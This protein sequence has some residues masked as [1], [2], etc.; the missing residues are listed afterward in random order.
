MEGQAPDDDWDPSCI[1]IESQGEIIATVDAALVTQEPEVKHAKYGD[2][3][4]ALDYGLRPAQERAWMSPTEAEAEAQLHSDSERL[5]HPNRCIVIGVTIDGLAL[6]LYCSNNEDAE[7]VEPPQPKPLQSEQEGRVN[8]VERKM[9]VW[10]DL[11]AKRNLAFRYKMEL[12]H[13]EQAAYESHMAQTLRHFLETPAQVKLVMQYMLDQA[14][15]DFHLRPVVHRLGPLLSDQVKE[16]RTTARPPRTKATAP[17]HGTWPLQSAPEPGGQDKAKLTRFRIYSCRAKPGVNGAPWKE[18]KQCIH[19]WAKTAPLSAMND[20]HLIVFY[21][22]DITT[23]TYRVWT[24][25]RQ[26]QVAVA[27]WKADALPR[28]M[29]VPATPDGVRTTHGT[30]ALGADGHCALAMQAGVLVWNALAP[31]ECDEPATLLLLEGREVSAVHM[32]AG[33][34]VTL[35]TVLGESFTLG[36]RTGELHAYDALRG[37][38]PV[39]G[40]QFRPLAKSRFML[41]VMGMTLCAPYDAKMINIDR[42]VAFDTCGGL[43]YVLSKYGMIKVFDAYTRRVC[44]EFP[45][46]DEPSKTPFLQHCY[47]G[48]RAGADT[49]YVLYPEGRVRCI[50]LGKVGK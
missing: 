45:A 28:Q 44:H 16:H 49:L 41:S 13:L 36:W 40:V 50:K 4:P 17:L 32:A 42:P 43:I 20:T 29:L 48:V 18:S 7:K 27:H 31:P 21:Q 14:R 46:P 39:W 25:D 8:E 23:F 35:G 24:L 33:D 22:S 10:Y 47:Q 34:C 15:V 19:T 3:R 5:A 12:L 1:K 11:M 6:A 38:E 2:D 30:L 37:I 26:K 9:F